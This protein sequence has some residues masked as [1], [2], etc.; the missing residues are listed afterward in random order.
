M[1][2][3]LG[4]VTRHSMGDLTLHKFN[5]TV[6]AAADTYGITNLPGALGCWITPWAAAVTAYLSVNYT[7]SST[8][9]T[10]EFVGENAATSANVYLLTGG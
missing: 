2:A 10:L 5:F 3:T 4:S 1:T 6:I 9:V 8:G 7:N